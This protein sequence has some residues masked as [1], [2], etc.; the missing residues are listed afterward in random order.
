MGSGG[1]LGPSTGLETMSG[2]RLAGGE[3][4]AQEGSGGWGGAWVCGSGVSSRISGRVEERC[5][6]R[7]QSCHLCSSLSLCWS[8]QGGQD[9]RAGAQAVALTASLQPL[10]DAGQ[11]LPLLKRG[12]PL[13][14]CPCSAPTLD[15]LL[16]PPLPTTAP[17]YLPPLLKV[18]EI[19]LGTNF[20]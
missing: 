2:D 12:R 18:D 8:T 11:D 5:Q 14:L 20:V 9:G 15:P 13:D 17:P 3:V 16:P 19:P 7:P 6:T 1:Q 10:L 4:K